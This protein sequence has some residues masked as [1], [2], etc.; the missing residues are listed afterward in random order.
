[1]K[2]SSHA[3]TVTSS[4]WQ[5]VSRSA[6]RNLKGLISG[7]VH[8]QWMRRIRCSHMIVIRNEGD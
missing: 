3:T 6:G 4:N 1:M 7:L 2:D 5:A 8:M